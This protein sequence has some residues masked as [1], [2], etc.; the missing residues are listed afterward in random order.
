M[1]SIRRFIN[2]ESY[3]WD[4][5]RHTA[6]LRALKMK[7]EGREIKPSALLI[8]GDESCISNALV[9]EMREKGLQSKTWCWKQ[10]QKCYNIVGVVY[11]NKFAEYGRQI[12]VKL[13]LY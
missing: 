11:F 12:E 7:R 8:V 10:Y 5:S 6:R 9:A 13:G 1:L 4:I 3:N 2:E